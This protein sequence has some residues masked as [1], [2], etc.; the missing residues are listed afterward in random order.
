MFKESFEVLDRLESI[1]KFYKLEKNLQI[2]AM[3]KG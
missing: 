2:N 3:I 1:V